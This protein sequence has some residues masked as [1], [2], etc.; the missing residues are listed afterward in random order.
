[1]PELEITLL[2]IALD[3]IKSAVVV[4]IKGEGKLMKQKAF[5]DRIAAL[6]AAA[7][8]EFSKVDDSEALGLILRRITSA[9]DWSERKRW[10]RFWR[11][12]V[13]YQLTDKES[14]VLKHR[15]P[16]IHEAYI[17][18]TEYDLALDDDPKT[19]RR[20]YEERLRELGHDAS[21]F[22]NI[23]VRVLLILLGYEA[24]FIDATAPAGTPLSVGHAG[25]A[26]PR[27]NLQTAPVS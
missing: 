19:D 16:A 14:E 24:D 10:E 22:R 3:G 7:E 18:D 5:D 17:L 8:A 23:V 12:H 6:V 25:S 9:N 2:A 27:F 1:V 21:I 20:P 4:K 13:G 15:G 11:D 26:D